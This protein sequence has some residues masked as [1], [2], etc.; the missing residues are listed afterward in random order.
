MDLLWTMLLMKQH[1]SR[2]LIVYKELDI[3]YRPSKQKTKVRLRIQYYRNFDL[4]S[5]YALIILINFQFKQSQGL[6]HIYIR[7]VKCIHIVLV[8]E[9]CNKEV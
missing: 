8:F 1:H 4:K 7:N 3:K 2:N 9:Y 5:Y 6:F